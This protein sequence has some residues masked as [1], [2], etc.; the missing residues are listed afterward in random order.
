MGNQNAAKMAVLYYNNR[1]VIAYHYIRSGIGEALQLYCRYCIFTECCYDP[2]PV[3]YNL[4][5]SI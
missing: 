5:T 1:P 2:A 3:S 4:E